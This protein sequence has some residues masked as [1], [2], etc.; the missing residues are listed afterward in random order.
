V[1][2]DL[3]GS[4]GDFLAAVRN[5]DTDL[6]KLLPE[7]NSLQKVLDHLEATTT[8]ELLADE[9]FERRR[10]WQ[11]SGLFYA[12]TGRLRE[13]IELFARLN[14][15]LCEARVRLQS[16]LPCGMPLVWISDFTER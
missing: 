14:E 16:W 5:L 4:A 7:R 12:H 15:R 6:G 2:Q 13:A 9:A 1:A 8:E 10:L 3:P 11:D